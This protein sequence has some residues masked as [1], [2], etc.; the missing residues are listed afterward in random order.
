MSPGCPPRGLLSPFP[1]SH[2]LLFL[3]LAHCSYFS[4][5]Q[6]RSESLAGHVSS[7]GG[8]AWFRHA[9]G[10]VSRVVLV[11]TGVSW[12]ARGPLTALEMKGIRATLIR[13]LLCP[14]WEGAGHSEMSQPWSQALDT[15]R[16][17]RPGVRTPGLNPDA[18]IF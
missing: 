14:S 9:G 12:P 3:L 11:G 6:A 18:A 17:A 8:S 15:G 1:F 10:W 4:G 2:F 13:H 5:R 16:S 7:V